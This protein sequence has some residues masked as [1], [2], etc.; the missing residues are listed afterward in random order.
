MKLIAPSGSTVGWARFLCI[1]IMDNIN[2]FLRCWF[3][4]IDRLDLIYFLMTTLWMWWV[5][6]SL[7]RWWSWRQCYY[8]QEDAV[9]AASLALFIVRKSHSA[10]CVTV[11]SYRFCLYCYGVVFY[12]LRLC[13]SKIALKYYSRYNGKHLKSSY[14]RGIGINRGNTNIQSCVYCCGSAETI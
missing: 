9:S 7:K 11:E 2:D 1:H 6:S 5:E 10:I 4:Y 3:S 8:C 12:G 13:V 14:K